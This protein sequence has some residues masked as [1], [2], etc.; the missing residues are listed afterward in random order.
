MDPAVDGQ[1]FTETLLSAVRFQRHIRPQVITSIQ[2]PTVSTAPLNLCTVTIFHRFTS[3]GWLQALQ[4]I[5][6]AL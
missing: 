6:Q 2:E 4:N 3:P 1:T 5:L